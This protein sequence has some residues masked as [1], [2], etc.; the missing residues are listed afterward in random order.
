MLEMQTTKITNDTYTNMDGS[1]KYSF[2]KSIH[3]FAINDDLHNH[4]K[5]SLMSLNRLIMCFYNIK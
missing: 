5:H 1:I 2:D 4:N 3:L